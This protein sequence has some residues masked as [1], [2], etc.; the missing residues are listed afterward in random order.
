MDT[1]MKWEWP[2]LTA[3]PAILALSA[4][5][6]CKDNG[7]CG[8]VVDD[9]F[10]GLTDCADAADPDD[11][12]G[13]TYLC[14]TDASGFPQDVC[15]GGRSGQIVHHDDEV[16]YLGECD[17]FGGQFSGTVNATDHYDPGPARNDYMRVPAPHLDVHFYNDNRVGGVYHLM[18][19]YTADQCQACDAGICFTPCKGFMPDPPVD[20]DGTWYPLLDAAPGDY[21][22]IVAPDMDYINFYGG[23]GGPMNYIITCVPRP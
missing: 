8:N 13:C 18:D 16:I 1:V 6:G 17:I 7:L 4:R 21:A 14:N 11:I 10:D 20:A 22:F 9:D 3:S 15:D 2:Q 19:L 23:G 12:C 5:A